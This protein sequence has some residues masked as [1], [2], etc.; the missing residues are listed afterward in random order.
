MDGGTTAS[1]HD[2][3]NSIYWLKDT[4]IDIL[5]IT[6]FVC[7]MVILLESK[8]GQTKLPL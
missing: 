3:R 6:I 1:Y 5:E 8:I 7:Q 2:G 4:T